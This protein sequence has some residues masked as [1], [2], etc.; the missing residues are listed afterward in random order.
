MSRDRT[1]TLPLN[2]PHIEKYLRYIFRAPKKGPIQVFRDHEAGKYLY[3]RV[4]YT[5]PDQLP[6]QKTG[7]QVELVLPAHGNDLSRN[8]CIYYTADDITRINDYLEAI[9]YLDFRQM[10]HTGVHDLRMTRKM[11]I[12]IFSD[13][14]YGTDK[15]EML[16]KDEYRRRKRAQAFIMKVKSEFS[17]G[18][19]VNFDH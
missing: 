2:K 9:A 10:V 15:Y 3:S 6:R 12:E 5:T 17:Y 7:H 11:V 14:V 8:H 19:A 13:M 1:I 18:T 16:K 4:R